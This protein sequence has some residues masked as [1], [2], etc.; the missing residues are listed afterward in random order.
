M[1]LDRSCIYAEL[2]I[3]LKHIE[4]ECV[5]TALSDRNLIFPCLLVAI[6]GRFLTED[7]SCCIY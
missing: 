1:L 4:L 3:E 7:H 2:R 5:F 6:V